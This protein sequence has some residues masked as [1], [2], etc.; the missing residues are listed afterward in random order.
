TK[1]PA[2]YAAADLFLMPSTGEGFGIV[3]LEAMATGTPALGL[4]C[5]GSV[6]P[7]LDGE[8]GFVSNEENLAD[9]I[10]KA[11]SFER[12]TDLS[13]RVHATFG[14]NLF[15]QQVWALQGKLSGNSFHSGAPTCAV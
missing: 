5:D 7:L 9:N 13:E 10:A 1:L 4:D 12:V 8:L 14:Q 3:F 6:D 15:R 2:L 11:L